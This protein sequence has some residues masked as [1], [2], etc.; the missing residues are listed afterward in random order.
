MKLTDSDQQFMNLINN[1]FPDL[2]L[3]NISA[4]YNNGK[5]IIKD[6]RF[7]LRKSSAIYFIAHNQ[8][9]LLVCPTYQLTAL[10]CNSN[11]RLDYNRY[12]SINGMTTSEFDTILNN[13][14]A[15]NLPSAVFY[16]VDPGENPGD[17]HLT[18]LASLRNPPRS[19]FRYFIYEKTYGWV[20]NHFFW[21]GEKL[22]CFGNKWISNL[23]LNNNEW[24]YVKEYNIEDGS[25]IP[26][27][28]LTYD[29]KL[30]YIDSDRENFGAYWFDPNTLE[31]GFIKFPAIPTFVS[32]N[33]ATTEKDGYVH[34]EGVDPATSN[35]VN[36]WI[37]ITTGE[38]LDEITAPEMMFETIIPLN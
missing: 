14:Y 6:F 1:D 20:T 4:T 26:K 7:E 22:V 33:T 15:N 18:K 11:E 28:E 13:E 32:I 27:Y 23:D 5:T 30:W 25:T 38:M 3:E 29:G 19:E 24:K 34:C 31:Y 10:N 2:N 12:W 21:N 35:T 8:I 36:I 17:I 37:N 9:Y 16:Q